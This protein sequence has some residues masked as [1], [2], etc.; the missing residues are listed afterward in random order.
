MRVLRALAIGLGGLLA[1]LG[2]AAFAARFA[3]GPVAILAGGPFRSG[4]LVDPPPGDW[5]FAAEI[6]EVELALLAPPRS[7]T[8][9]IVVHEGVPYVPCGFLDVPLW[10][11]W[12]HEALEDGRAVLRIDGK[13]YPR[14]AVR[15][16]DPRLHATLAGLAARKYGFAEGGE[17]PGPD[18]LW[19]FRMDPR[20]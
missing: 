6:D 13:L 16:T 4:E 3:D 11:Q 1:A 2:L 9:W 7:R 8:T 17:L 12:P 14:Q 15:V 10:K 5:S 19:F 20:P 18:E